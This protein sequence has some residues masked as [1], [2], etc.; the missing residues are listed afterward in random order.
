MKEAEVRERAFA[1]PLTVWLLVGY[2]R[3]LPRDLE[4]AALVDGA[5][6][7]E[8]LLKIVLPLAAPGIFTAAPVTGLPCPNMRLWRRRP[9]SWPPDP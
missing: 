9:I 3:Q 5:T 4:E 7:V 1:M 2:F 6:R 8:T